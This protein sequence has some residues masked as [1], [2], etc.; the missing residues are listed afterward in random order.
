LCLYIHLPVMTLLRGGRET[1]HQFHYRWVLGTHRPW[2]HTTAGQPEHCSS[3]RVV[4][5]RWQ[6]RWRRYCS[7]LAGWR[8][9]VAMS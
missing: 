8:P 2:T 3:W 6:W 4:A 5:R 9:S 1:R 7:Q